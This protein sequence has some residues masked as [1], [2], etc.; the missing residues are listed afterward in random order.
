MLASLQTLA[1]D[2]LRLSLWLVLLALVFVPLERLW[3]AHKQP[4]RRAGWLTDLGHYF[5]NGLLP[6]LVLAPLLGLVALA[7][8]GLVPT[9]LH[10]WVAE[11]PVG[12]RIAAALVV[13]EI[14]FYWGHRLMHTVPWLWPF[15]AVHHSAT[16]MDWLV[17][18][19]AHPFDMVF[20]RLCGYVPLYIS[21]LA[22]PLAAGG[23]AVSIAVL[24]LGV[25]WGFFVHANVRWRFGPL[26]HVLA[27]PAFH[28]WHH[29]ND[30]P[31]TLNKNY[32][33]LLPWVDRIFG[34]FYLPAQLPLH[35][36]TDTPIPKHLLG[37][38]LQPLGLAKDSGSSSNRE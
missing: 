23:D 21:G 3:A 17:N 32:A 37:Q 4:L 20:Q 16:Q 9:G 36:G 29:A 30:G 13:G 24:L 8:H 19:R 18:T 5:I 22:H 38:W 15:H 27:T 7:L 2:L 12:A 28:H 14:G 11:L 33:A 6:A 25:V 34:S 1:T 10:A 26:E 35:Y 31:A